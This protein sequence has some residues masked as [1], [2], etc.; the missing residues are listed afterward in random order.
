M[1]ESA[2]AAT[3]TEPAAVA[4]PAAA[5]P[6]A[7][8]AVGGAAAAERPQMKPLSLE[9]APMLSNGAADFDSSR[10]SLLKAPALALPPALRTDTLPPH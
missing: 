2:T 4:A 9:N 8:A 10:L 1:S 7:T 3:W 6:P 5:A